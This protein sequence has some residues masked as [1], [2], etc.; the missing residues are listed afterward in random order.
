MRISGPYIGIGKR[1]G[2]AAVVVLPDELLL[3]FDD[4]GNASGMIGGDATSLAD[5]NTAFGSPASPFTS[6]SVVGNVVNLGGGSN[7][8][9]PDNLFSTNWD[10]FGHL[11]SIVD[12][13]GCIVAAG[14]NS[15]GDYVQG[16]NDND[17]LITVTLPALVTAGDF[18]FKGCTVLATPDFSALVTAGIGCF[19]LCVALTTPDFSALIT[20]GDYCF[21][22]CTLLSA[23]VFTLLEEVG[24]GCF[25]TDGG[26]GCISF[27]TMNFPALLELGTT[28]GDDSVF[29]GITGKVITMTVP[30][31][32]MICDD[33]DPDGDIAYLVANNISVTITQV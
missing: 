26:T 32:L 6:I 12:T 29:T 16:L 19:T 28:H 14:I 15:F 5:W 21:V 22:D 20:A 18:C 23:P 17:V 4:I 8:T 2:S 30:A 13:L 33:G 27:L 1:S 10:S 24:D 3:T 7:I 11:I 9:V 31:A 25:G